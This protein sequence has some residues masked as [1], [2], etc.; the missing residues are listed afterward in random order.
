MRTT[1]A[2][3][4][5]SA[6]GRSAWDADRGRHPVR[7]AICCA[8]RDSSAAGRLPRPFSLGAEALPGARAS[9]VNGYQFEWDLA[10]A[11]SNF[12]K[13]GVTFDEATTVFADPLAF[14]M[15]V[16]FAERLPCTRLISARPATRREQT[17]YEEEG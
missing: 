7:H 6:D 15:V 10:K 5:A 12:R 13:H 2:R 8:A 9:F 3:T 17:R 1:G 4:A 16:S 14:L 11:E